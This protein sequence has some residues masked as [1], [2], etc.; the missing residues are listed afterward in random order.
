M[1]NLFFVVLTGLILASGA[2][3]LVVDETG[4]LSP[5]QLSALNS[6]TADGTVAI[7]IAASTNGHSI[8]AYSDSWAAK[9]KAGGDPALDVLITVV[10]SQHQLYISTAKDIHARF[11]SQDASQVVQGILIPSFKAG[12]WNGG[13]SQA[14]TA[15]QAHLGTQTQTSTSTQVIPQTRAVSGQEHAS[16]GI[17]VFFGVVAVFLLGLLVVAPWWKRFKHFEF[18]VS[19]GRPDF[20]LP[21]EVE[22]QEKVRDALE[23]LQDLH[24]ALP[25]GLNKRLAFYRRRKDD[26]QAAY[27]TCVMAVELVRQQAEAQQRFEQ[28]K[29][30]ASNLPPAEQERLW[31]LEAQY[32]NSGNNASFLLEN[33]VLMNLWS[34]ALQPQN[35]FIENN[36]FIDNDDMRQGSWNNDN[37]WGGSGGDFGGG[38]GDFGG[39]G[40][41]FGGSGG[42]W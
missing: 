1:R 22:S 6:Q 23:M 41:D 21:P 20:V 39:G 25:L 17:W 9:T 3:A 5:N 30:N 29:A 35:V 31:A 4:L 27:Q 7:H 38:G 2:S 10:P 32:R 28:I 11:S 15:I 8:K 26:F 16:G 34:Q 36:T 40:D 37:G 33:L 13:L 14:V 12:D 18:V 24:N 42:S 19:S